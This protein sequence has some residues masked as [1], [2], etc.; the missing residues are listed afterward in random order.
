MESELIGMKRI[1]LYLIV[2]LLAFHGEMQA[3]KLVVTLLDGTQVFYSITDTQVFYSITDTDRPVMEFADGMVTV[4]ADSFSFG[5]IREFRL[6][7]DDDAVKGLSA[8]LSG[9]QLDHGRIYLNQAS[10]VSVFSLKGQRVE[11]PASVKDRL[12]VLDVSA[13]PAGVY[14]IKTDKTSF[15]FVK[16]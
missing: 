15:K 7:K 12:T 14:V 16:K 6:V 3:R 1:L 10:A 2:M 8:D 5:D 4:K 9:L 11:V 13:L